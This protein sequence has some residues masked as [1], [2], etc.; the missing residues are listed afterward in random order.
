M[1]SLIEKPMFIIYQN[2][3]SFKNLYKNYIS[4]GKIVVDASAKKNAKGP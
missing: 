2:W 3:V 4:W 1:F